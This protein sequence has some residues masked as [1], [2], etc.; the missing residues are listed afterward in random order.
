MDRFLPETRIHGVPP[1]PESARLHVVGAAIVREGKC[2][3][4]QRSSEMSLPGLW[5]FPGGKVQSGEDPRQALCRE[6]R[7]ELGIEILPDRWL[8]RGFGRSGGLIV[9]LDVFV[10]AL[11]RNDP[12]DLLEHSAHGWFEPREFASLSWPEADQPLLAPLRRYL[13]SETE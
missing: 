1:V 10:A 3:V 6:I 2:L 4:T 8:G 5:E 13:L 7:E 9:C 11:V 12:I